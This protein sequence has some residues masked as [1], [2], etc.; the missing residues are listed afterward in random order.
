MQRDQAYSLREQWN[1]RPKAERTTKVLTIASGKGGVGKSNFALNFGLSLAEL[2]KKIVLIDLDIGMANIDIL[3]GMI[4]K[5]HLLDMIEQRMTIWDVLEKGPN[6][7]EL[8]AGGSGLIHLLQLEEEERAYFFQELEK[9]HG[10]ADFIIIDTGAGVTAESL[11]C[12]L[13][14]DE[15]ILLMTPE[16]TAIADA[17]SVVK[18]LNSRQPTLSF[19]LVVNRVKH[20][21]EGL[22]AASKFKTAVQ[23]FL[24]KEIKVFGAIPEDANVIKSVS[25]QVPVFL[26][27]PRST[28]AVTI[29]RLAERFLTGSGDVS[30]RGG[31][32]GFIRKLAR[33]I[34]Y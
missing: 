31:M 22:E 15:I 6:Q 3:M 25:K 28:S 17:Y 20:Q 18:I 26:A 7:L 14:A 8:L 23:S 34:D 5:Y 12:H 9:L 30:E 21:Q 16:P 2:G 24:Q 10:Y 13:S 32:K 29:K 4:P 11:R 19:Q 1:S 27:A 33:M